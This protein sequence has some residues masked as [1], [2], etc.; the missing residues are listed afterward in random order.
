MARLRD[1]KLDPKKKRSFIKFKGEATRSKNKLK[2]KGKA[3][4]KG[5]S[6]TSHKKAPSSAVLKRRLRSTRGR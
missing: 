3:V 5:S 1:M 4:I 2:V 6:P